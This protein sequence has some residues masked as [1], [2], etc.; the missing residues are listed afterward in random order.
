MTAVE[1]SH[2][3]VEERYDAAIAYYWKA[4]RNNKRAYKLTRVLT[5]VLGAIVTLV[6][7]LSSAKFVTGDA[8]WE[9][10]FSL[11]TPIL[12]A[13]LAIVGGFSQTF[14]WGAA[15]QDMVMTAERLEKERD[16][17]K[18]TKPENR[19]LAK[20]VA[21]LNDLVLTESQGFFSRIFATTKMAT[22][23]GEVT[24][25]SILEITPR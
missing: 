1:N 18:V 13:V 21:I 22:T 20:E 8:M 4:S 12:A 5:I 3:F 6:A 17:F 14:Q 11:G 19:D 9:R 25:R 7:S 24:A 23:K 15:W 16:R 2:K 10:V